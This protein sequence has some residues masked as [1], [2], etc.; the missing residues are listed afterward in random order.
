MPVS[1]QH[2]MDIPP[3]HPSIRLSKA[4]AHYD[5]TLTTLENAIAQ[6]ETA[7]SLPTVTEVLVARDAVEYALTSVSSTAKDEPLAEYGPDHTSTQAQSYVQLLELDQRL[8]AQSEAITAAVDL[9]TYRQSL[10]PDASAWWWFL[11]PEEPK[12]HAGDRFDW[13]WNGLT[14]VFLV[15]TVSFAT[16][17]ARAFSE[18]GFD[19]LGIFGSFSQGAGLALVAGGTFTS[20][21]K[22]VVEGVLE[23]F[24]I[25]THYHAEITCAFSATLLLASGAMH[26]N[27]HRFGQHYYSWGQ[28]DRRRGDNITAL[29]SYQKALNFAPDN[30]IIYAAMGQVSENMGRLEEATAYYEQ[31]VALSDAAS[32]L[33]LGRITLFNA[34]QDVGWTAEIDEATIRQVEFLF[35]LADLFNTLRDEEGNAS[36][37]IDVV[38][39][40]H[41]HFG[42]LELAKV[43]LSRNIYRSVDRRN[44]D[45]RTIDRRN[46]DRSDLD[47]SNPESRIPEPSESPTAEQLELITDAK[48]HL[49]RAKQHFQSAHL[50]ELMLLATSSEPSDQESLVNKIILLLDLPDEFRQEP[51]DL[52]LLRLS[53]RQ[54]MPL[55]E[56]FISEDLSPQQLDT[57]I[58]RLAKEITFDLAKPRC[59]LALT[60]FLES[61][62]LSPSPNLP[63]VDTPSSGDS[64]RSRTNTADADNDT[65]RIRMMTNVMETTQ[66]QCG[67]TNV[68]DS[69]LSTDDP[70]YRSH[71]VNLLRLNLYDKTLIRELFEA[72]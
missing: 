54:S 18:E 68:V 44:V 29:K 45:R 24:K 19:V 27:L 72:P 33:G 10:N 2:S 62:L 21:G 39:E 4:I 32:A 17:T 63:R 13:V 55:L 3:P 1:P 58:K 5:T 70:S 52:L 6:P 35:E 41:T 66:E 46:V 12:K 15:G 65:V 69:S 49:S 67:A 31:G 36:E 48:T 60:E 26:A 51:L 64:E 40:Q 23:S 9:A 38:I 16:S 71:T 7:V 56:R 42:L 43:D 47:T 30:K 22:K 14:V 8:R 57:I 11:E 20:R 61:S 59:Y 34:L 50:E 53:Q 28:A 37:I 25:P